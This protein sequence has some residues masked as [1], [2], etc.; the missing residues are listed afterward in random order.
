MCASCGI[1]SHD[2]SVLIADPR[3]EPGLPPIR[4][5]ALRHGDF[6]IYFAGSLLAM[7]GDNIE[8][9]ISYWELFV[10]FQSP[11][12][13]GFATVSHWLPFLLF[14]VFFGN[15][16]DRYDCRRII[17]AG[18]GLFMAVSL[19]WGYL[20]LT[21]SLQPWHA[22]VLLVLHGLAGALWAPAGQLILHNMVGS[23]TLP[24]AVRLNATARNLGI[25]A[26]PAVGAGLMLT[27]GSGWGMVANVLT[28][29]PLMVWLHFTPYTG[30]VQQ[31]A[32]ARISRSGMGLLDAWRV[33]RSI[34]DNPVIV[35]MVMLAGVSS[36]LIGS[37][38][39]PQ[40][41][42]FA[43]ILGVHEA[44]LMYGA[45]LAA[46]AAGGVVGGFLL[47]GTG[48]LRPSPRNA[49][50]STIAMAAALVGFAMTSNYVVALV[51]LFCAG[52][53]NLSAYSM[54]QALVQLGA[55]SDRR[56]QVVGLF[57][58]AQSGL[59]AGSGL[60]IGLLGALVGVQW[61]L[62]INAALLFGAAVALLGLGGILAAPT[63][64][65][66]D[67]TLRRMPDPR[68]IPLGDPSRASIPVEG[69]P[70]R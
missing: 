45:L 51:L 52:M 43:R 53:A 46:N 63:A 7:M 68:S 35:S 30:H 42:E 16:A 48:L 59:R 61:S 3:A 9:V 66:K 10:A 23:S 37:A 15:L 14:S 27:L 6:R 65:L 49:I 40:M 8:H 21:G 41:P 47:E 32:V 24:S 13:A 64:N 2:P 36:F 29:L 19:G 39:H 38:L 58:M 56:G 60:T 44:G 62:G 31:P 22:V 11:L 50:L 4:F 18:M 12:L 55:P 1:T 26:G 69:V 67:Q 17:Q 20:F 33:F 54:A 5:E 34:R 25:L 57:N 70:P 28:Y